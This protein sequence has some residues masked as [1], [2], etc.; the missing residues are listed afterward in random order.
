MNCGIRDGE[1]VC[2]TC[3]IRDG[4]CGISLNDQMTQAAMVKRT[5][6]WTGHQTILKM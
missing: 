6:I 2:G 3:G 1:C 4:E 5:M